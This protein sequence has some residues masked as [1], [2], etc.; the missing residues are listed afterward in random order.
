MGP[1]MKGEKGK[2]AATDRIKKMEKD[3]D[4]TKGEIKKVLFKM[5]LP[6]V[7]GMLL[8]TA[9][10]LIDTFFVAMLGSDQLAAISVTFPVVFVFISIAFGLSIGSTALVSQAVGSRN[11]KKASN[12][13]EHSLLIALVSGVV[14]AVLGI[15]FSP[16]LFSF[17][18]VRGHVLD[19]TIEYAN[20][21]F[22]GFMFMFTGFIARGVIQAGG[23]TATPTRNM[24]IGIVANIILDPLFIFGFGPI[25]SMGLFGAALATVLGRGLIAF[26]NLYHLLSGSS[27]IKIR[28]KAFKLDYTAFLRILKI[29]LPSSLSQATN[30]VGLILLMSMVGNFGTAAIAAFGVGMRLE[31]L[32]ILPIVALSSAFIPFVGQNLGAG[33]I[34]RVKEGLKLCSYAVVIFLLLFSLIMFFL[35][36]YIYSPFS[37]DSEVIR[38]GSDYLRFV[39]FGYVFLGLH[40]IFG[41]AFQAA[42]KTIMQLWLSLVRW[43]FTIA[44]AYFLIMSM[45]LNGVWLSLPLGNFL[46]LILSATVLKSGYWLRGWVEAEP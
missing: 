45:G 6:I 46:T 19:M 40:F 2:V 12:M 11:S 24:A 14:V 3:R 42:G 27:R 20:L 10:N 1:E 8:H 22:I 43:A 30:S 18:G 5:A 25:P 35:P 13:A 36:H 17:M 23:D 29:G 28:L 9:F 33:K 26:L 44:L 15:M 7:L 38:I 41:A 37:S 39:A 34:G 31:T 32:V 4:L 21:I 16:P